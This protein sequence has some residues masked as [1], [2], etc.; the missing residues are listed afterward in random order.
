MNT[1]DQIKEWADRGWT[2]ADVAQALGLSVDKFIDYQR[3]IGFKWPMCRSI[4]HRNRAQN[5]HTPAKME[6]MSKARKGRMDSL[7]VYTVRGVTANRKELAKL[8]GVVSY[9]S[10]HRRMAEGWDIEK[11]L[12]TPSTKR[13]SKWKG[14]AE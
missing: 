3:S 1:V 14:E 12:F 7:P 11:A 4:A 2:R 9:T 8:F 6:A 10:V 13:R 5:N